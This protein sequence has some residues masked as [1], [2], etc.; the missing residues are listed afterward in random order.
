MQPL[1]YYLYNIIINIIS[2]KVAYMRQ[3]DEIEV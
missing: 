2:I 1:Y 3:N